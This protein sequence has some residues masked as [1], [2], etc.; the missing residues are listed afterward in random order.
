MTQLSAALPHPEHDAQFYSGVATKRLVAWLLDAGLMMLI[1]VIFGIVTL[2]IGFLLLPV[3]FVFIDAIYRWMTLSGR[4]ATLGMRLVGIEFRN[5]RGERFD[6]AEAALHTA[7]YIGCWI[8]MPLQL[9]S[10]LMMGV[11][12]G[13]RGLPDM[14]LGSACINSPDE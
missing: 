13:G 6:A 10:A 14:L 9:I 1:C 2:G 7:A 8:V 5:G 3:V 12:E 11:N 4:S